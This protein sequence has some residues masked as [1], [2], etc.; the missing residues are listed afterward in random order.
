MERRLTEPAARVKLYYPNE[1]FLLECLRCCLPI[2]TEKV[3]FVLTGW[4]IWDMPFRGPSGSLLYRW[5]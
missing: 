5:S 3:M 1:Y 4:L 2:F